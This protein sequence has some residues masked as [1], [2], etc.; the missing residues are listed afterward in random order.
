M[1]LWAA[2]GTY[3]ECAT[4]LHQLTQVMCNP[5]KDAW[6]C[7]LHMVNWMC[8]NR[9]CGIMFLD[10]GDPHPI[11]FSD[12]SIKPD[13]TDSKSQYSI[14]MM[15]YKGPVATVSKKLPHVGLSTFHNEYM[16]LCYATAHAVWM[17]QLLQE[18]GWGFIVT[19]PTPLMGDNIASNQL[20]AK[21]FIT[22]RNQYIYLVYHYVKEVHAMGWINY[23][24]YYI[25]SEFNLADLLT[26]PVPREVICKLYDQFT[27]YRPGWWK[28]ITEMKWKAK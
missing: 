10:K 16:A 2:Q 17:C 13:D 25:P 27:G 15:W 18:T 1:L 21:D 26:K 8:V 12:A 23:K 11:V 9:S 19:E 28:M 24:P 6:K 5:S 7:A 22:T 20:V 4:G 14:V 3:P